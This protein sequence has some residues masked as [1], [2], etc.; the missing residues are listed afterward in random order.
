MY[1]P[2]LFQPPRVVG[3]PMMAMLKIHGLTIGHP[4][5]YFN[6]SYT[7][8]PKVILTHIHPIP[9]SSFPPSTTIQP[10]AP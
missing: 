2:S 1:I 4:I 8:T 10:F 7:P 9:I 5:W 6:I 3:A